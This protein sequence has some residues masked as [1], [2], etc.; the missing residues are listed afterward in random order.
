MPPGTGC[1]TNCRGARGS[2]RRS[3]RS[4]AGLTVD[5]AQAA[6]LTPAN[7]PGYWTPERIASAIP[8]DPSVSGSY[9]P[10]ADGGWVALSDL[11]GLTPQ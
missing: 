10:T 9:L 5:D 2:C 6:Y 1:A 11:E 4:W 3:A 7:D 8:L